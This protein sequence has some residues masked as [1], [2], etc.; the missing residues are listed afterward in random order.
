MV[1][2]NP[3]V[4]QFRGRGRSVIHGHDHG[5]GLVEVVAV[6]QSA[7]PSGRADCASRGVA[8]VVTST[9]RRASWPRPARS[10]HAPIPRVPRPVL[11]GSAACWS[12]ATPLIEI[13]GRAGRGRGAGRSVA[14]FTL[15]RLEIGE[16]AIYPH[17][18]GES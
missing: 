11:I 6:N 7:R 8:V 9:G 12:M 16:S 15:T 1:R 4:G 14:L 13:S 5:H 3:V 18:M 17:S 2:R 10:L